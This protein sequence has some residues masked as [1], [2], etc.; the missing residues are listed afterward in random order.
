M[1]L[2]KRNMMIQ[3]ELQKMDVAGS[4]LEFGKD[5]R[6]MLEYLAD[7]ECL[8]DVYLCAS[9]YGHSDDREEMVSETHGVR[10]I[11]VGDDYFIVGPR[12]PVHSS[13]ITMGRI[14][15]IRIHND[16]EAGDIVSLVDERDMD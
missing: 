7:S 3:T 8:V 4:T 14:S 9:A 10:I 12:R 1:F 15:M 6:G 2:R 5:W 13:V 16:E 11:Y